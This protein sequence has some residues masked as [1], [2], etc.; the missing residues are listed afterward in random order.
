MA[1]ATPA[2]HNDIVAALAGQ[3]RRTTAAAQE[4]RDDEFGCFKNRKNSLAIR[5]ER[6]IAQPDARL[7]V[8]FAL[9]LDLWTRA[10]ELPFTQ[11]LEGWDLGQIEH[12]ARLDV[13]GRNVQVGIMVDAK[14]AHRMG[15]KEGGGK[16]SREQ[17]VEAHTT[18]IRIS[19]GDRI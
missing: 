1:K 12:I 3:G 7:L 6:K 8:G 11:Q 15:L 9:E 5:R 18:L 14:T 2:L 16:E 19:A 13:L 10:I 17:E 4:L